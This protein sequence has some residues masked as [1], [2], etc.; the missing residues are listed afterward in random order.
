MK[1]RRISIGL[2]LLLIFSVISANCRVNETGA[3]FLPN[4]FYSGEMSNTDL[5]LLTVTSYESTSGA[6]ASIEL[7][8]AFDPKEYNYNVAISSLTTQ[9]TI[10]AV[11]SDK[12]SE[13]SIDTIVGSSRTMELVEDT[14]AIDISVAA[15]DGV[16]IKSYTINF[17]RSLELDECRLLNF[18]ATSPDKESM[19]LSPTFDPNVKDYKIMVAWN[20]L[21][22]VVKPTAVSK[23]S[24]IQV[25]GEK[26]VSGNEKLVVLSLA[27][28]DS[29]NSEVI[30]IVVVANSGSTSLYNVTVMR[31]IKPVFTKNEARLQ[32]IKVSMGPNES[33][34][35]IY[36]DADGNFFPDNSLAFNKDVLSYSCV[37]FG[38]TKVNVTAKAMSDAITSMSIDGTA[39]TPSTL[40]EGKMTQEVSLTAGVIK[41]IPIQV[42]SEDGTITQV[43]TLRVRL[44]NVYELFF[45]IYGP[46]ARANKAS[47]TPKP[48]G[49]YD[50]TFYGAIKDYD[51]ENYMHWVVTVSGT[52]ATNSMTYVNYDNGD[53]GMPLV[54]SNGGFK[55]NGGMSVKINGLSGSGIGPQTG[56]ITM[57]TPEGDLIAVLHV[58]YI[59]TNK[60][61]TSRNADSYTSIDYM[62]TSG[63]VLYYD[64]DPDNKNLGSA[65][66]DPANQWTANSFWHP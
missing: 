25:N 22:V 26:V 38:Y 32:Y 27:K 17:T 19:N 45:G 36:Q 2:W 37:V 30:K 64:A 63:T 16:T 12:R 1:I 21:Y 9:V 11:S 48:S 50:K 24:A 15:P 43:Y 5:K 6:T 29:V 14:R 20:H 66:W 49:A 13:V 7:T 3:Y 40:V 28:G 51:A 35:Q 39:G 8:P 60:D 33:S 42:V 46:V 65:Y 23:V 18:Q 54:G 53:Q 58:H 52:T 57:L 4:L 55:L 31:A 10:V 59:I 47:W 34:R 62:G 41:E 56:D 61:A 44:L